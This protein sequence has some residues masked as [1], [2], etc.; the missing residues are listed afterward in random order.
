MKKKITIQL[1]GKKC[2]KNENNFVL[3]NFFLNL[4]LMP[5][6]TFETYIFLHRFWKVEYNC[7]NV[8]IFQFFSIYILGSGLNLT[9]SLSV[10]ID[11]VLLTYGN[12]F[13]ELYRGYRLLGHWEFVQCL[14][15]LQ[16]PSLFICVLVF[17][18]PD[19]ALK[20]QKKVD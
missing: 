2:Q 11:F 19:L 6:K 12:P 17:E 8:W 5:L 14:S 9:Q 3:N 18:R 10:V 20:I 1:K 13:Y 15:F 16:S 4:F 7:L